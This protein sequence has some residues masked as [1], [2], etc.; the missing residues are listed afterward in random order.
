MKRILIQDK[1]LSLDTLDSIKDFVEGDFKEKTVEVDFAS[2]LSEIR[3]EPTD[4]NLIICHP[5][6]RPRSCCIPYLV[7]ANESNV[8]MVFT[9]KTITKGFEELEAMSDQFK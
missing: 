3:R 2:C 1:T 4:Y 6:I 7:R 5:H 9:Y 8:P